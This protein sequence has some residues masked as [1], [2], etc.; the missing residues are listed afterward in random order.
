[1]GTAA[2]FVV[3][4]DLYPWCNASDSSFIRILSSHML[5]TED[6]QT[7]LFLKYLR[8]GTTDSITFYSGVR[9]ETPL[10]PTARPL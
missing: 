7:R 10:T 5:S 8:A 4:S 2:A 1:M 9:K 6:I 3:G